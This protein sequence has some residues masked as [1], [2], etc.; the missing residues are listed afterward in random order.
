MKFLEGKTPS[1][2]KKII[3][4]LVLGVVTVCAL[5]YT[6][7]LSGGTPVKTKNPGNS[8]KTS[9]NS[10]RSNSSSSETAQNPIQA[11]APNEFI[12]TA[13][14]DNPFPPLADGGTSRN[15]FAFYEPP[16]PAPKT[17]LIKDV[18]TPTPT[19]T[20]PIQLA[21]MNPS[22]A[23]AGTQGFQMELGGDRFT[24]DTKVLFNGVEIPTQFKS[25]QQLTAQVSAQN[26]AGEGKRQISLR[27]PDGKL[28]SNVLEF[29]VQPPPLPNFNFVGLVA[30]KRYDNDTALLQNKQN[31]EYISVRLN[32]PV[33]D[34]FR[35]VSISSQ[36]VWVVDTALKLRHKLAFIN[37][38]D[39]SRAGVVPGQGIRN[40]SA[41]P[42]SLGFDPNAQPQFQSIPGIPDNIPRYVP[43]QPVQAPPQPQPNPDNK[44]R[45]SD[46][47]DDDPNF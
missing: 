19:P 47:N 4:A 6:F 37:E 34:R 22:G 36:E 25:P 35:V 15:I 10:N 17:E 24:P 9:A 39:A 18:P 43:P 12:P 38:K 8:N 31:K 40:S 42:P 14:P 28:F 11:P 26:I 33:P 1:E 20:P 21:A 27:T 23:Y 7:V 16:P 5:F 29:D 32:D 3:T 41:A 44:Q 45:N 13:I 46:D 30:R 2:R